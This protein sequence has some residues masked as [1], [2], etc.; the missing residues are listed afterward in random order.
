MIPREAYLRK[1]HIFEKIIIFERIIS[2]KLL[3]REGAKSLEVEFS[4]D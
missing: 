2:F 1:D 4:D 3:T